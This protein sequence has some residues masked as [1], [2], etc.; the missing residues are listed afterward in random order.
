ME[1]RDHQFLYQD[2]EASNFMNTENYDQVTCRPTSLAG[3]LSQPEMKV[4]LSVHEVPGLDPASAKAILE[5]V[6]TDRRSKAR[7]PPLLQACRAPNGV[8]TMVPPLSGPA[9]ESWS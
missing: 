6:D 9:P 3:S 5:V 8:R 2:G 1:D 7:P 4:I